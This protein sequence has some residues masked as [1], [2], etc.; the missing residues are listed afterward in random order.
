MFARFNPT[1]QSGEVYD[2]VDRIVLETPADGDPSINLVAVKRIEMDG[3]TQR[4][5]KSSKVEQI[6]TADQTDEDGSTIPSNLSETFAVLDPVTGADTG[7]TM[8]YSTAMAIV[9]SLT[10]HVLDKTPARFQ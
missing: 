3:V 4:V 2:A 8:D 9:Y 1:T 10:K 5:S 7:Q 6:R